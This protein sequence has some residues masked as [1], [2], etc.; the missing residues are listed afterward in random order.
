[1]IVKQ[2]WFNLDG[3]RL[4]ELGIPFHLV[5]RIGYLIVNLTSL[6][7]EYL[8]KCSLPTEISMVLCLN[9]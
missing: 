3:L 5:N 2:R 1:M 6:E 8:Q 4:S 7:S 9:L